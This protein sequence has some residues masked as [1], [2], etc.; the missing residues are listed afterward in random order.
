MWKRMSIHADLTVEQPVDA[1]HVACMSSISCQSIG[2]FVTTYAVTLQ[3]CILHTLHNST[4]NQGIH[5]AQDLP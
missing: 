3:P 2:S 1:L 4:I 5:G